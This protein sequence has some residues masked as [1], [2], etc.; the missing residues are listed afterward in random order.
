MQFHTEYDYF[1]R[2]FLMKKVVIEAGWWI[3]ASVNKVIIV[4]GNGSLHVHHQANTWANDDLVND[5][6]MVP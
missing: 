2:S 5:G 3:W 4:P 6:Q 1:G